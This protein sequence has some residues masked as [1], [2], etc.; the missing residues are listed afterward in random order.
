MLT[1][2]LKVK[3]INFLIVTP[4]PKLSSEY[5]SSYLL[6]SPWFPTGGG[7]T[8]LRGVWKSIGV[9]EALEFSQ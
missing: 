9:I 5:N 8:P 1:R 7:T 2:A 4:G 6:Y 3:G